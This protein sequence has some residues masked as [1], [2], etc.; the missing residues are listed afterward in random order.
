[1]KKIITAMICLIILVS[2]MGLATSKNV[3][4]DSA[5]FVIYRLS[6]DGEISPVEVDIKD[7][8]GKDIGQALEDICTTLFENDAEM[9]QYVRSLSENNTENETCC[10]TCTK[11]SFQ[12]GMVRVKSHGRGL[13]F[14]TKTKIEI[15]TKFK[16]FKIMLPRIRFTARKPIVFC[17]Y[18]SDVRA[19]TT[20]HSIIGSYLN[21]NATGKIVTGNHSVFVRHFIGYT[22]WCGRFSNL[23][24]SFLPRAFS[25]VG[26]YVIC[27]KIC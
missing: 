14:K 4:E 10:D 27:K 17:N 20:F 12:L 21:E 19:K 15:N 3:E 25:G 18:P 5:K 2:S 1:M 22:T 7:V 26:R 6:P 9:Q 24:S 11:W 16:F 23:F 13:H 8:E